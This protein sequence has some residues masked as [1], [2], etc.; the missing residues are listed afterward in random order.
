M[1]EAAIKGWCPGALRPLL[2]G[3]GLVVRV[4]PH[5][6]R[7]DAKQA[8]GIADL[9]ERHGNGLIDL[10]SRANLQIRGVGDDGHRLL[11]DGLSQ[12]GLLDPDPATERRRNVLV[13]PFWRMS[14][15]TPS[16]AA[17]LERALADCALDLPTKFGFAIDDGAGRAL[18]AASADVRIERDVAGTLIVRADGAEFGRPVLREGAVAAALALA[19]WFV[20]SGGAGGGRGRMAAH[21]RAGARLPEMLRGRAQPAPMMAG[22]LPGLYPQGALVGAALG[23]LTPSALRHL[24]GLAPALRTAPWRMILAEGLRAMPRH[25]DFITRPDDPLLRATACSGAPRCREAHADTRELAAALAPRLA[26][27]AR[28]HVSGCAKGCAHSGPATITLVATGA[29]YDLVSNGS[30]RDAPVRC[31]LSA[32]DILASPS[33]VGGH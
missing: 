13:S 32:A 17:E 14:D 4:R 29:G 16:L 18:A 6:G 2:S 9:A 20:T 27:D 1:S 30:T 8:A 12:L 7:L 26:P 11:L 10:T 3:D 5:G 19:E 25:N 28:L 15:E 21:L 22:V 23:Q 33:I 31:G 24:A